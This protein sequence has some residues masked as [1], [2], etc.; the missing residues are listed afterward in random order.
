MKNQ[1]PQNK[2]L[3]ESLEYPLDENQ[4][5][6]FL[7]LF[8][9]ELIRHSLKEPYEPEKVPAHGFVKK[10]PKPKENLKSLV[11]KELSRE[12]IQEKEDLGKAVNKTKQFKPSSKQLTSQI[13]NVGIPKLRVP[14]AKLPQRFEYLKPMI[15]EKRIDL[16]E[17]NILV[18]NPHIRE[19]ETKGPNENVFVFGNAGKKQTEIIL[20]N[21]EVDEVINRFSKAA[22]I[23]MFEGLFRV[24]V[25]KLI[26]SA[27]ISEERGSKFLIKKMAQNTAPRK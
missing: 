20:S 18:N 10:I 24:V 15:T 13:R 22:K 14:R 17:L 21:E 12:R 27:V 5:K 3:K 11:K 16:G 23:P 8:T 25:G 1:S 6:L 4:K 26:F 7:L 19:I 9:K 2:I